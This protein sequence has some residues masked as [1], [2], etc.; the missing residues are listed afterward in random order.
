MGAR[1]NAITVMLTRDAPSPT[2]SIHLLD[3]ATQVKLASETNVPVE[4]SI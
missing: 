1:P 2:V 4:I 3:A